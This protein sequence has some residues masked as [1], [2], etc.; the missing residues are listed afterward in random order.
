VPGGVPNQ[1]IPRR[2][3]ASAIRAALD[4]DRTMLQQRIDVAQLHNR[5][6]LLTPRE[7]E[8]LALL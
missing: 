1:T 4:R 2:T 7:R 6:D 5:Y 8:V 3:T